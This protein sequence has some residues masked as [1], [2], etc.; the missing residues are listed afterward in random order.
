MIKQ[1][2]ASLFETIGQEFK[3]SGSELIVTVGEECKPTEC[4]HKLPTACAQ[5][6]GSAFAHLLCRLKSVTL[7]EVQGGKNKIPAYDTSCFEQQCHLFV[8]ILMNQFMENR[9]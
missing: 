1:Q 5:Q 6:F 9:Q 7:V 3:L 4:Y 8:T 2:L